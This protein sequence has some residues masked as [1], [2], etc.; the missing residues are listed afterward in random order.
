MGEVVRRTNSY[1]GIWFFPVQPPE[2][3]EHFLRPGGAD[4]GGGS[5]D[6]QMSLTEGSTAENVVTTT[7]EAYVAD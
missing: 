5:P 7:Y 6:C 4:N 2:V 1:V 3:V